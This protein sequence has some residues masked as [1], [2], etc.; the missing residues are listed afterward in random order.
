MW[1]GQRGD[2]TVV[3]CNMSDEP[4]ELPNAGP[5]SIRLSTIRARADERVDRALSLAPW[6]AVI[7]WRD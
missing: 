5:G 2:R 1:A 3:A 7:L 4:A 6:E